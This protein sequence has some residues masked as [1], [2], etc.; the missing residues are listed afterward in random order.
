M[1]PILKKDLLLAA[2]KEKGLVQRPLWLIGLSVPFCFFL[3]FHWIFS[4]QLGFPTFPIIPG[5]LAIGKI[6]TPFLF[7]FS[8]LYGGLL[9]EVEFKERTLEPLFCTLLTSR[10]IVW[11]KFLGSLIQWGTHLLAAFPILLVMNFWVGLPV[12]FLGEAM[13]L[14]LLILSWGFSCGL[15][16]GIFLSGRRFLRESSLIVLG[17][18][19]VIGVLQWL[20][21][22]FEGSD[23]LFWILLATPFGIPMVFD[24]IWQGGTTS[25]LFPDHLFF[26]GLGLLNGIEI[27]LVLSLAGRCLDRI[28]EFRSIHS[29]N[30]SIL[31]ALKSIFSFFT[32]DHRKIFRF[33]ASKRLLDR[34]PLFWFVLQFQTP[35]LLMFYGLFLLIF[36]SIIDSFSLNNYSIKEIC[37]N[38]VILEAPWIVWTGFPWLYNFS[39]HTSLEEWIQTGLGPEPF[40]KTQRKIVLPFGWVIVGEFLG[41][42]V[43]IRCGKLQASVSDWLVWEWGLCGIVAL[44]IIIEVW[45]FWSFLRRHFLSSLHPVWILGVWWSGGLFVAVK[46]DRFSSWIQLMLAIGAVLMIPLSYEIHQ[47]LRRKIFQEYPIRILDLLEQKTVK[48]PSSVR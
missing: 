23:G 33:L 44:M 11:G 31:S 38:G 7:V 22:V 42:A 25:T 48:E 24:K 9:I 18:F 35:L 37:I 8:T 27:F 6:I 19:I 4:S 20:M 36:Y 40:L 30:D 14:F 47:H 28:W 39:H 34:D 1:W 26:F 10:E 5:L 41:L 29:S 12:A 3:L 17:I 45:T 13:F 43:W 2:R 21:E 32:V 46:A 16:F 15:L